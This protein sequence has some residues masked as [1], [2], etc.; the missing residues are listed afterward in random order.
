MASTSAFS[1]TI[2]PIGSSGTLVHSINNAGDV[3]GLSASGQGFLFSGGIFFSLDVP[4]PYV[5]NALG[6]N[7]AGQV[8]GESFD[9]LAN[10]THGFLYS[11][12]TYSSIDYP[13]I[14]QEDTIA[15]DINDSGTIVGDYGLSQRHG[16]VYS[17]CVFTTLDYPGAYDTNLR[18]TN[19]AG[20]IVGTYELSFGGPSHGFL[21]RGGSFFSIEYPGSSETVPNGINNLGQIVGVYAS[22]PGSLSSFIY[23]SGQFSQFAVPGASTTELWD[24]NDNRVIS[25][26]IEPQRQGFVTS[27]APE[28]SALF[29]VSGALAFLAIRPARFWRE[30]CRAARSGDQ[31]P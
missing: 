3:V 12:G 22:S 14:H 5:T 28:P 17:N 16:F 4:G 23:S 15:W 13:S 9:A 6:I 31:Q 25:G 19:N 24:I 29:L 1:A 27:I 26:T 2:T 8:V 30:A 11:G 7:N 20:D 18:A 21:F 10:L